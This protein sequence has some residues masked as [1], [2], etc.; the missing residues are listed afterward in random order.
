MIPL[1]WYAAFIVALSYSRAYPIERE[2]EIES[3]AEEDQLLEADIAGD[4]QL[5]LEWILQ[6][7]N[8]MGKEQA[9]LKTTTY[10]QALFL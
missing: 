2:N 6:R 7:E 8:L 9:Y 3:H 4:K 10:K 1:R 5:T